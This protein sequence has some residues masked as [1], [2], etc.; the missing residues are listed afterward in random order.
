MYITQRSHLFCPLTQWPQHLTHNCNQS[1][2]NNFENV[3][4]EQHLVNQI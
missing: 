3:L 2:A 4:K 1:K